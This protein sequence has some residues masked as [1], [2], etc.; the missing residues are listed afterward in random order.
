MHIHERLFNVWLQNSLPPHL[1]YNYLHKYVWPLSARARAGSDRCIQ[2]LAHPKTCPHVL[3]LY[4][5]CKNQAL[6]SGMTPTPLTPVPTLIYSVDLNLP[7][8]I[9]S[10]ENK[11]ERKPFLGLQTK[12]LRTFALQTADLVPYEHCQPGSSSTVEGPHV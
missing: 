2:G 3:F 6:I 5:W 1:C 11:R 4:R 9:M 7:P 8:L 10:E 12:R